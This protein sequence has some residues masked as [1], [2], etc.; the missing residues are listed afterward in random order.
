M[1]TTVSQPEVSRP[2]PD[3][4]RS[5]PEINECH[6]EIRQSKLDTQKRNPDPAL[7]DGGTRSR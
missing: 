4:S 3:T 5:E 2:D 6:E 7:R 1:Q